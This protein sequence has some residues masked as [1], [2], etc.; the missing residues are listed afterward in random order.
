MVYGGAGG[1]LGN[2]FTTVLVL[3]ILFGAASSATQDEFT[4]RAKEN[5][6]SGLAKVMGVAVDISAKDEQQPSP[7][8][9][10]VDQPN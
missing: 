7:A 9:G 6:V 8:A 10:A 1:V 3:L 2:L 5:L 4:K